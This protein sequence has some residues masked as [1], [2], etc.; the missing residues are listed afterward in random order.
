ML[1]SFLCL[2][3]GKNS[4]HKE[5]SYIINIYLIISINL[6]KVYNVQLLNLKFFK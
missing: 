4:S 3:N 2:G 6:D 1:I 5:L